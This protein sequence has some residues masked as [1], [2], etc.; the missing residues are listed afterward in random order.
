VRTRVRAIVFGAALGAPIPRVA[1]ADD[2]RP[3]LAFSA[4]E[5][6]GDM[7]MQELTLHGNVVLTY[8]RFRLTSPDL[9]LR[10][11]PR[12]I[13]VNG[14][15]EVV[16]CPC[17][18]PPVAVGFSQALVAPP[19][20]LL[21]R[22]PRLR[23][24]GVTVFA[25]PWFWMRAPVRAGIL[26]PVVAW[27]GGDGLL[28]GE[29]I[30][31]PWKHGDGYDE[32]DLTGAGYLQG[33][34]EISARLRT[35]SS[36]NRF[37]WDHLR[38]DLFALDAHG[39]SEQGGGAVAWD[40]DAIRG[41]RARTATLTLDEAARGYDHAAAESSAR[42]GGALIGLGVR[43]VG[44]R[45][46]SGPS[47]RP[48]WGPRLTMGSSGAVGA[49]GDW[50]ALGDYTVLSDPALGVT[51]LGRIA[52]GVE[53]AARPGP[54]AA[55]IGLRGQTMVAAMGD[56]SGLDAMG[57]ARADVGLPLVRAYPDESGP[58][59]S[60]IEPLGETSVVA[61]RT[62]GSYWSATGRPVALQA[63]RVA[64]ASLGLRTTWGRWL[65]HSGA[66]I[67]GS[68]G[69]VASLDGEPVNDPAL[70]PASAPR[71][72]RTA[73]R[74]RSAWSSR[75]IGLGG[76]GAALVRA[77]LGHVTTG[78]VRLGPRDGVHIALGAAGRTGVEPVLARALATPRAAEPS[79]GWLAHE[80]WS[81]SA[82]VGGQLTDSIDAMVSADAD[83]SDR[84]VL[85]VRGK[86]GYTHPCRCL[87]VD[88][89][90]ARRI[91]REGVD[92]WVSIDLAPR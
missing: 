49:V 58:L 68:I 4:D 72:P 29:G 15:G 19:A 89:F 41:E 44:A 17:A 22:Q 84:T 6:S 13:E 25:L 18:D 43:A 79:G 63:G 35:S 85:G 66:S 61:A 67:E 12:G 14:P 64:L 21:L 91:G 82:E 88:A 37:R 57:A 45:G 46:S 55:R 33:G 56:T 32:L 71:G 54:F 27:R 62:S 39:A 40:V 53:L 76:E 20:D 3:P 30:H 31:V 9:V 80:G 52:G 90:A 50:D 36:T 16:F 75:Y 5:V 28:L 34:F 73:V 59:L 38:G 10:R 92:V 2:G 86:A 47:T 24:G 81:G 8:E 23:V 83:L 69:S 77:P 7:R 60:L 74:W 65:G 48:V 51:E 42:I 78:R 26:P 11:T 70:D 87:S 1:V